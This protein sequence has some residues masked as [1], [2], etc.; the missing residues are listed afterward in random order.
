V[1][2]HTM[3]GL[4]SAFVGIIIPVIIIW[5]LYKDNVKAFFGK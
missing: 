1:A 4:F 5:Y 3:G 2:V